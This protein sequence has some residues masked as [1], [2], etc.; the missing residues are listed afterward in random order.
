MTIFQVGFDISKKK[1]T[2]VVVRLNAK[3][4][5][6]AN[7]KAYQ[8]ILNLEPEEREDLLNSIDSSFWDE[9]DDNFEIEGNSFHKFPI[10]FFD[11]NLDISTEED[12]IDNSISE[13][14]LKLNIGEK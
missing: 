4:E 1:F 7:Q 3:D 5:K 14:Q 9:E 13:N 12:P 6:E 10:E 8:K 2:S 11:A